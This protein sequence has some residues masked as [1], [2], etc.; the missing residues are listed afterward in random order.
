MMLCPCGSGRYLNECCGPII[1]GTLASTPE[2]LMRSRY[3]AFTQKNL[4][5]LEHTHAPEIHD[6]FNRAE[7]ERTASEIEWLGLDVLRSTECDDTGTVE[8]VI[9]FRRDGK[10]L[11]Q[12]ELAK[13]RRDDGR[14]LYVKG[15]V[16]GKPPPRHVVKIG[17]NN[18]CPCGS[19][20][21]YKK[22]CGSSP[23]V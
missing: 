16:S 12:Y 21:K 13:F 6:D 4:E 17:R 1:D 5:Y 3:T 8:F 11:S 19:S 18:P 14:W 22:C 15:E 23:S 7:A 2:I 10:E 20:K 9:R